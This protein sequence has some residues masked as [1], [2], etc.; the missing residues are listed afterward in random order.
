MSLILF[1]SRKRYDKSASRPRRSEAID[2][3]SRRFG[4]FPRAFV[5]R[6]HEYHV[7]AVER[8]WTTSTRR[9]GGQVQRHYFQVRCAEGKFDLY[10]DVMHNT[11]HIAR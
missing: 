10:Q 8:C 3:R 2:M 6:G 4:Y 9:N 1:G 7:E 11:W 5:W